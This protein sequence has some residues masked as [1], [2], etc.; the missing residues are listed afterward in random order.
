MGLALRGFK[1]LARLWNPISCPGNGTNPPRN[2]SITKRSDQLM[3]LSA[4]IYAHLW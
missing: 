3:G 2:P 1:T 4:F